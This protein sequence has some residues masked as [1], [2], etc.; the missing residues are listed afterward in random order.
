MLAIIPDKGPCGTVAILLPCGILVTENIVG[1]HSECHWRETYS[2]EERDN[3]C[4]KKKSTTHVVG[5]GRMR[6]REREG[7]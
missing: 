3:R 6:G 2:S 5:K 7:N 4:M 1:H